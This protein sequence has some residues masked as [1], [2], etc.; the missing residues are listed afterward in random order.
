M[1]LS[2]GAFR[3]LAAA[4]GLAILSTAAARADWTLQD[5]DFQEQQHFTINTWTPADGLSITTQ[6]GKLATYPTRNILSLSSGLKPV[7]DPASRGWRLT[8]RNGDVLYGDPSN[9]SGKSLI[10]KTQELGQLAV[11]LKRVATL[12]GPVY[13][14]ASAGDK[15]KNIPSSPDHDLVVFRE[16][17]DRLEGL[18][19]AIDD[20]S[21]QLLTDGTDTPTPIATNKIDTVIF[22]GAKPPRDIPPLSVRL[23]FYSGTVYTVPLEGQEKPFQWSLGKLTVKDAAGREHTANSDRIV[24]AQVMGGRVVYLTDL[25][26]VSEEQSSFLNTAWPAQLNK[27]V[28]GQPLR[29]A[30][31]T[32]AN[33][34]GVHTQSTLTYQL[35]GTFNTLTFRVGLDDSAAPLGEA[36][37]SVVLDGKTLWKTGDK[38]L[39]PG[40]ITS[41]ITLPIAGGKRLELHADPT[42]RLDVQGRLDWI[43]IALR[44]K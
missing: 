5:S 14:P 27:N 33:G 36:K 34:L 37:A 13:G 16:T 41:E 6:S 15:S 11:P 8:L 35:D 40:L 7:S 43:N 17:G 26:F 20:T 12:S 28:L 38:P 18:V 1:N 44:R 31:N 2:R 22:G 4:L 24:S 19:T 30:R 23:S 9:F 3:N 21:L 32:Y 39:K 29:I 10:F 25:D 42:D